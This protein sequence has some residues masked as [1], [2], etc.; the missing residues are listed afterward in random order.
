MEAARAGEHG[1]GFA[2]VAD[3]VRNL[4][5][6]AAQASREVTGMI[7][8]SVGRAREGT[9]VA[10]D[11][12]K[13]LAAIVGDVTK[14]AT[15][16]DGIAKASDEQAQ[17][18]E[19]VNVAV[20][21]MDTVTQQNA[22]GAEESASAAEELS[23]QAAAVKGTV[24]TLAVVI[25]GGGAGQKHTTAGT[26]TAS[27]VRRTPG[28]WKGYQTGKTTARASGVPGITTR[29]TSGVRPPPVEEGEFGQF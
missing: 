18:V 6:R 26:T 7:E 1:K 10:S 3:E 24:N 12:G 23:A 29:V 25:R 27:D 2:V 17:G 28:Q 14:V 19:Q 8:D 16:V 11:V 4:A 5:Q 13:V 21:Q 9:A 15:L 20:S 22:A